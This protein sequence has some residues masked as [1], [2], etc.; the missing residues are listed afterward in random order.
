[1]GRTPRVRQTGAPKYLE[2]KYKT[3]SINLP[4]TQIAFCKQLVKDE[5]IDSV[6]ACYRNAMH[7]WIVAVKEELK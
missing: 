4:Q 3:H 6:S 1:M 2:G 5:M 7:L